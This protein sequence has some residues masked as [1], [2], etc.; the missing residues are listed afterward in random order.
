MVRGDEE[1]KEDIELGR[2]TTSNDSGIDGGLQ[3][4]VGHQA[5]KVKEDGEGVPLLP[6]LPYMS[7]PIQASSYNVSN[8]P[9]HA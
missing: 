7:G 2:R 4:A 5:M 1:L 6:S 3:S 9:P 8:H